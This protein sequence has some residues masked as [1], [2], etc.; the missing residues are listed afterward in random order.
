[1][2][3]LLSTHTLLQGKLPDPDERKALMSRTK[4]GWTTIDMSWPETFE[5]ITVGGYATSSALTSD[6]RNSSE[7]KSRQL[8]MVDIDSGMTISELFDDAFYDAFGAGFYVTP[9]HTDDDPRFRIM[10]RSEQPVEKHDE[11][12]QVMRSLLHI[13]DTADKQCKDA[14]RLYFGT[15][16]CRIKESRDN[17]LT[18]DVI[19][20]LIDADKER[21]AELSLVVDLPNWKRTLSGTGNMQTFD[22]LRCIRDHLKQMTTGQRNEHFCKIWGIIEHCTF[23]QEQA[24][25]IIELHR[26]V[27]P[28][29]T[30]QRQL[31][32]KFTGR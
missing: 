22:G 24:N 27:D 3:V 12:C 8:F 18:N 16:D 9:S 21:E 10:F 15:V 30:R 17:I 1:M 25:L 2:I 32:I 23:T 19:Q 4:Y 14:S 11:C 26:M 28:D 5:W 20:L 7:F 13:Y 29:K 31:Q 6:Y